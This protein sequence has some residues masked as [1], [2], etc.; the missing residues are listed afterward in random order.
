MKDIILCLDGKEIGS[1]LD[2]PIHKLRSKGMEAEQVPPKIQLPDYYHAIILTLKQ[3]YHPLKTHIQ[4]QQSREIIMKY[5]RSRN[6]KIYL[7]VEL[8]KTLNVH[9]HGCMMATDKDPTQAE[10]TMRRFRRYMGRKLGFLYIKPI[11]NLN[12]WDTYCKKE[13]TLTKQILNQNIIIQY[14]RQ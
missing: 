4:Y 9:Y 12:K 1:L 6:I 8:T 14:P 13:I 10:I 11:T 5:V 2:E 7:V 3:T